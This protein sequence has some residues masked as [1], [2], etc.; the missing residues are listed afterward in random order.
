MTTDELE[1]LSSKLW[2]F[3]V[4]ATP[5]D[6]QFY[7]TLRPSSEVAIIVVSETIEELYKMCALITDAFR[8]GETNALQP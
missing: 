2:L 6:G 1:E 7:S 3:R 8:Q 4:Y 5:K